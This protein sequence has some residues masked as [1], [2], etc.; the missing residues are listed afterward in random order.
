[1]HEFYADKP[2]TFDYEKSVQLQL[3][4]M[5]KSELENS[6]IKICQTNVR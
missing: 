2:M 1:M 5:K 4:E 6:E 3:T